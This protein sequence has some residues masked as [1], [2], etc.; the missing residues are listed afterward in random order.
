MAIAMPLEALARVARRCV[1]RHAVSRDV[2]ERGGR[3]KLG[4]ASLARA[5]EG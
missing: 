2:R 3:K 5:A 1:M 4:S